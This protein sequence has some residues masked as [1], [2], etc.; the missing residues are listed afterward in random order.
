ML[1]IF[2]VCFGGSNIIISDFLS[3]SWRC[4]HKWWWMAWWRRIDSKGLMGVD[5]K[6]IMGL[7]VCFFNTYLYTLVYLL[8]EGFSKLKR[9][10]LNITN[11]FSGYPWCTTF[12]WFLSYM[13]TLFISVCVKF[14]VLFRA[15][16][17]CVVG[18]V[19]VNKVGEILV[20]FSDHCFS[21]SVMLW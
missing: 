3:L 12:F 17:C 13:V 14:F 6:G 2:S 9:W 11:Q 19:S 8:V 21:S 4:P 1:V 5:P 7:F 18:T 16:A 20:P 10:L 15:V